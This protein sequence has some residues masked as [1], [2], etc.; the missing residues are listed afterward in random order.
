MSQIEEKRPVFILINKFYSPHSIIRC[1]PRLIC[2][3]PHDFI[4]IIS[5]QIGE[6]D[7]F[8]LLRVIRPHI[9]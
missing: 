9:I 4:P 5:R 8:S 6:T 1:K 2:I 7:T 3:I